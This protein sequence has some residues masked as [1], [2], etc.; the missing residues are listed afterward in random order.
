MTILLR[1]ALQ[2]ALE[3]VFRGFFP[4][5]ARRIDLQRLAAATRMLA[6]RSQHSSRASALSW[7]RVSWL[8]TS[9]ASP[10]GTRTTEQRAERSRRRDNAWYTACVK[11]GNADRE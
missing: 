8:P 6:F 3:R 9:R 2:P 4:E 11:A 7:F 10:V 1:H 5:V